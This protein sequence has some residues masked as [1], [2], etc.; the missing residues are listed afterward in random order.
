[1]HLSIKIKNS[2]SYVIG[3]NQII[4]LQLDLPIIIVLSIH[5]YHIKYSSM[6]VYNLE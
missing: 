1:M 3:Y 2:N 4:N 6:L 5:Q